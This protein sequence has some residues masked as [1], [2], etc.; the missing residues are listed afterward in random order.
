MWWPL[1][2]SAITESDK[3]A[4]INF[5][6]TSDRYTCGPK[7]KEFE[8][9]WSKWLGCKHSLFVTSG[10]GAN[11]I[12]CDLGGTRQWGPSGSRKSQY[13]WAKPTLKASGWFV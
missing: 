6:S 9:A 2:Q 11:F 4:L 10:S 7:V 13:G 8:D 1:M 5:I 3:Q 12:H